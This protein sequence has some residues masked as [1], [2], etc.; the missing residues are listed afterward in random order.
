MYELS[1]GLLR[2]SNLR[3]AVSQAQ[4]GVFGAPPAVGGTTS[5]ALNADVQVVFF[6]GERKARVLVNGKEQS[7][8]T[9]VEQ[10]SRRMGA[11][12]LPGARGF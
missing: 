10:G 4:Y 6:E 7:A 8:R 9:V 1:Q 3:T 5:S 2:E 12:P 11:R